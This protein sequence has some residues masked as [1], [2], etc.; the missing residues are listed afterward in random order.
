M[1]FRKLAAKRQIQKLIEANPYLFDCET[2]T[3]FGKLLGDPTHPAWPNFNQAPI[4]QGKFYF[5]PDKTINVID[6]DFQNHYQNLTPE[7]WWTARI[8]K[9]SFA[10]HFECWGFPYEF[11]FIDLDEDG[12]SANLSWFKS[13][14]GDRE[15]NKAPRRKGKSK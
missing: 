3:N 8:D 10:L 12:V 5:M 9:D 11:F 13:N 2:S 4:A 1:V 6:V 15:I 14:Y 7:K